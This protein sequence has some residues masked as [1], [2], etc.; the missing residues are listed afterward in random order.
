MARGVSVTGRGSCGAAVRPGWAAGLPR[1]GRPAVGGAGAR[2]PAGRQ[3]GTWRVAGP[4]RG[5]AVTAPVLRAGI[6]RHALPAPAGT[7]CRASSR[8]RSR[9]ER[10]GHTGGWSGYGYPVAASYDH[11]PADQHYRLARR[12]LTLPRTHRMISNLKTWIVGTDHGTS[13]GHLQVYLDEFTSGTTAAAPPLAAFPTLL[14]LGTHQP[15]CYLPAHHN[16]RKP[17]GSVSSTVPARPM[18]LA[19]GICGWIRRGSGPGGAGR[20]CGCR[21]RS[22]RCWSCFCGIRGWC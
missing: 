8:S 10:S 18:V 22:F 17:D 19:V 11:R 20:S 3:G 5:G 13:A 4:E 1:P 21:R 15:A 9:P 16:L 7:R 2:H 14:G 12:T 6:R